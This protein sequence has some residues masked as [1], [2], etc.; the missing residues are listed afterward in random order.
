MTGLQRMQ[1]K[2]LMFGLD[3]M[4]ND[5]YCHPV[6]TSAY[7]VCLAPCYVNVQLQEIIPGIQAIIMIV[8]VVTSKLGACLQAKLT[9][10]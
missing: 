5:V 6:K 10:K 7:P 9:C 8:H 3:H 4:I 1:Y 2:Y